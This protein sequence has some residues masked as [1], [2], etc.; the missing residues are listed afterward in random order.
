[1]AA[2]RLDQLIAQWEPRLRQ[3][4]LSAV[5]VMRDAAQIE[6]IVRMLER[7]DING[8]VRAVG[9][10]P[11]ELRAFD[12]ALREAYEASGNWNTNQLPLL[13]DPE[14]MQV[15][16]RF[17]VRNIR[18]EDWLRNYSATL[19]REITEDQLR[20]IRQHL[21]TGMQAGTNPRSVALELVGRINPAT[22]RREGGLIGLTASQEEWVRRYANELS[23]P[24]T[25]AR[26]IERSLRD[27]RFDPSVRKA[28]REGTS[29]PAETRASM[30]RAYSNRA[31]RYRAEAIARTEALRSLHAA[32]HEA[33]RQ[34]VD[35]GAIQQSQVTMIWRSAR[36]ARVRDTHASMDGQEQPFGVPFRSPSGAWLE[37]PGDPGAPAAE[38]INCRCILES[39]VD[40]LAGIR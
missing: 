5:Y 26:A 17:D 20:M 4:F 3:A 12:R 7:G 40:F 11:V 34:A 16:F 38:T 23:D 32:Q 25:M 9:I 37:Y 18:A 2:N 21:V 1:M 15:I 30:V 33:M 28:M 14:G 39:K 36:D 8:A 6:Q 19:A 10:S 24:K 27:R 31:L 13:R 35:S 29:L 22:G